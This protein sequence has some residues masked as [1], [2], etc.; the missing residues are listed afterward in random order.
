VGHGWAGLEE[1]ERTLAMIVIGEGDHVAV[2]TDRV[3]ATLLFPYHNLFIT[4]N[5]FFGK[6]YKLV[7]S[8]FYVPTYKYFC[9]LTTYELYIVFI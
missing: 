4:M 3:N 8:G 2:A 6:L 1:A 5:D 9:L 7:L